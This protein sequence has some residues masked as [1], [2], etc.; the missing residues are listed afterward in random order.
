MLWK[1]SSSSWM[2][3]LLAPDFAFEELEDASSVD[4]PVTLAA[5]LC[6]CALLFGLRPPLGAL[7]FFPL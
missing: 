3:L 4:L 6:L 1:S 5:S 7:R 2:T